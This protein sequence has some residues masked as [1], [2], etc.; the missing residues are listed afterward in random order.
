M[1]DYERAL[2][3]TKA[4]EAELLHATEASRLQALEVEGQ[5][6]VDSTYVT[7]LEEEQQWMMAQSQDEIMAKARERLHKGEADKVK[8]YEDKIKKLGRH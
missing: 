5:A 2:A 4:K 8:E 7:S 6:L 3:A 1:E